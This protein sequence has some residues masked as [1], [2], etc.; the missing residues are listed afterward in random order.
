MVPVYQSQA[1]NEEKRDALN[2]VLNSATLART[3]RL[4][5]LLRYL[6]EAEIEGRGAELNEYSIGVQA[7][8]QPAGYSP[9]ENSAVRSRIHELRH[10]LDKFYS[11]ESPGAPV[12]IQLLK[13]TYVPSFVRSGEVIAPV[14]EAPVADPA[15]R[16]VWPAI[17][18]AFA[19][20]A[21]VMLAIVRLPA[22]APRAK[23]VAGT[24]WTPEL[25]AVWAPFLEAKVPL[26]VS[27]ESRLFVRIGSVAVRD[28]SVDEMARVESS[29]RLMGIKE[30]F[31]QP[32]LY[33]NRNYA[34][35]GAV[36]AAFALSRLLGT[37]N[38]RLILKRSSGVGPD[39]TQD[40]DV[41]FLSKPSTDPVLR[42]LLARGPFVDERLRV[43]NLDPRA[44]EPAEWVAQPDPKDPDRSGTR[45]LLITMMPGLRPGRR[46]LSLACFNSEDP[47]ALAEYMTNPEHVKEMYGKMRLA[48]GKMPEFYQVVVKAVFRAQSPVQLEY[49]THRVLAGK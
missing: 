21:L 35:F 7:L 49:V 33:E 15:P 34:D 6:C 47:W 44:G 40:N 16:R 17:A 25:E 37:R 11:T 31:H 19:A 30:L 3:D 23:T 13:G 10:R 29:P 45:Y 46:F 28:W 38:P 32:Q 48:N 22:V 41:I 27:F 12:R 24:P 18:V 26:L 1:T 42:Q 14:V 43:R 20:G 9:A 4:K 36:Q 2:E 5:N 8:G 39:D